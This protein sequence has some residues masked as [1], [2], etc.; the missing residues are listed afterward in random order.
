MSSS[1]NIPSTVVDATE[2]FTFR[3]TKEH[4]TAATQRDVTVCA[5]ALGVMA[6]DAVVGVRIGARTARITFQD[7]VTRRYVLH[8]NDSDKIKA[9]DAAG[10]MAPG[11]Y[12]LLP[13]PASRKLG[14]RRG[15]TG[16]ATRAGRAK[17]VFTSPMLRHIQHIGQA[18]AVR[19]WADSA[20]R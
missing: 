17:T 19:I 2:P 14:S 3:V 11:T 12:T 9:F 7:G 1:G 20:V 15:Q 16:S 18:D 13:P 8:R 5:L 4:I 10:Y 6:K